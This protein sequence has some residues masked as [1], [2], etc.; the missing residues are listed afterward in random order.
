MLLDRVRLLVAD[1]WAGSLWT[2]GYLV[3]PTLFATLS[4]RTLAGAIAGSI[5][6]NQAWLSLA[7]ALA[8]LAL[9][10]VAHDLNAAQKRTVRMLA[11]LMLAC[12][13]LGYFALQPLMA[14]VKAASVN[15]VMTDANRSRFAI[16]HAVS[17]MLYLVQSGL[18]V[19]LVLKNSPVRATGS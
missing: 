17:S 19:A 14:E 8:M 15:G 2:V 12:L 5:F 7:C 3:A 16:L 18:A 9:A 4:D 11:L 13:L 6:R 1:L 10:S